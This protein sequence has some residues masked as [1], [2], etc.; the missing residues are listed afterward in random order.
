MEPEKKQENP[1]EVEEEEL[2]NEEEIINRY[3]QMKAMI[4]DL[5]YEIGKLQGDLSEHNL[6]ITALAKLEPD[7]KA[8]RLINK[9][10]VERTVKEVLPAV[11]QN[12]EGIEEVLKKMKSDLEIRTQQ[13]SEFAVKYKISVQPPQQQQP[14]NTVA[15]KPQDSDNSK[16]QQGVLI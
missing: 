3:K 14:Q 13:L 8:W 2:T 16:P 6:V 4:E 11:Q 12:K 9:V 10:L 7:R 1:P 5:Q 15:F